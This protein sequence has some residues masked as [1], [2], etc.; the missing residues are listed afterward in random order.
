MSKR[1]K[2]GI[3]LTEE[4]LKRL[5]E[6]C[7]ATGLLKSQAISL[8]INTYAAENLEKMKGEQRDKK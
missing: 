4:T 8:A 5:E 3:T 1:I 6:L 7:Q 2:V